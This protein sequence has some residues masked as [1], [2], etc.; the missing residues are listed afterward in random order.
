[1][2][3]R[4]PPAIRLHRRAVL[5]GLAGAVLA[6]PYLASA[7]TAGRPPIPLAL[8]A[9]PVRRT[10]SPNGPDSEIW[11]L[12]PETAGDQLAL[13]RGDIL[14]LT[15]HNDLTV[16]A[17]LNWHGLDGVADAE[18]LLARAPVPPGGREA[19]TLPLLHA[20]TLMCDARLLGDGQT[21]ATAA[22]AL[23]VGDDGL[24]ADRDEILLIE[25][26]RLRGDGNTTA[27][28]APSDS[29]PPIYTINGRPARD[30]AVRPNERARLRFI[31]GC[32]RNVIA[33]KI[34]N[35][36]VRIMT[37][38]GRP[39]EP[40]LAR[41][42]QLILAPGTR[43]DTIIDA[44]SASGSTA[45]I[46]IHDG[47]ATLSLAKIITS[48][49]PVRAAP[50]P[51]AA[52]VASGLPE[53]IDL[54]SALR[55][56]LSLDRA[57]DKNWITPMQFTPTA[58][59][60]FR[61]KRNRAVVL[62]LTNRTTITATFH[63][64]GHHFR[65]LDRLDDGWKPFWLDTLAVGPGQTHRI[66]FKAETAGRWLMESMAADWSTPRLIHHYVVE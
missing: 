30:I 48:G 41:D 10:L 18:P 13:R 31:N 34:E 59:P 66:A 28:G 23:R 57:A 16:P 64:H 26:W 14:A 40:F 24:V 6:A 29:A 3:T 65:L 32:Q 52:L 47:T 46:D 38:D 37:I 7:Q 50:L 15:F 54:R 25:D 11:T 58:A 51:P 62:A 61:V 19:I 60:A 33:L 39:A 12:E 20:G 45:R 4:V 56:G 2:R 27:A 8:R 49:E 21:R 55:V 43:I 5:A 9:K 44:T 1:M 17:V 53:Q 35:H 36:D 42:G 63:L 22:L